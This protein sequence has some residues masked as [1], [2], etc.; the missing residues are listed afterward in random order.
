VRWI[1]FEGRFPDDQNS[2]SASTKLTDVFGVTASIVFELGDPLRGEADPPSSQISPV[3]EIPMNKY[4]KSNTWEYD[5]GLAGQGSHVLAEAQA[6]R[7]KC[8]AKCALWQRVL[9]FDARHQFASLL[10]A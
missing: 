8:L 4:G 10:F 3:P 1:G 7:E 6:F 5:V 2:P 9:R